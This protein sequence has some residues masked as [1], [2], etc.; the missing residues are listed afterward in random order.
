MKKPEKIF[1]IVALLLLAG[2]VGYG[3]WESNRIDEKPTYVLAKVY[4]I[5]DTENGL[6]YEFKYIYDSVEYKGG[7]KGYAEMKDSLI[8]LKVSKNNP[9]LWKHVE[10]MP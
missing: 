7:L 4:A 10:R 5:H 1:S 9:K 3:V 8:V 6:I 2:L